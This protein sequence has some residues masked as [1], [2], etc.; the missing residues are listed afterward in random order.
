EEDRQGGADGMVIV[1][2][3]DRALVGKTLGQ[4]AR[5][6]GLSVFET[7][8]W[9]ARNGDAERLGGVVWSMRAV[10]MVDIEAWMREDWNGVSLDRS[11]DDLASCGRFTHPGTWGTSGRLIETFVKQRGTITLP[12]AIRS[13]TSVGAQALGLRD[14]GLLREGMMADVVVFDLE[15]LGTDATYLEPC[16]AQRG[17]EWVLVNGRAVVG[18]GQVMKGLRVGKVLARQNP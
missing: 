11:V 12:Y 10:G 15:T 6:K 8:L 3:P 18:D 14:R 4:V 1:G 16:K 9:L 17:V 13:L 5:D 7:V 2:F